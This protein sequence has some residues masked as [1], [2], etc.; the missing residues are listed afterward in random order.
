MLEVGLDFHL[1]FIK[2]PKIKKVTAQVQYE[3]LEQ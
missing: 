1:K 2:K 3:E